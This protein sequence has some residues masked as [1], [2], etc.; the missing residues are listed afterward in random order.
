[1]KYSKEDILAVFKQMRFSEPLAESPIFAAADHI[2][3]SILK[4][5]T[6]QE[7]ASDVRLALLASSQPDA[8]TGVP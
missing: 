2:K 1:M 8:L 7:L 3:W 5:A 6:D 4:P